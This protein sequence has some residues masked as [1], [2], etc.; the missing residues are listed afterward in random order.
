MNSHPH[1]QVGKTLLVF[2]NNCLTRPT[3]QSN[4]KN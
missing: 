4:K 2:W 1:G 3:F